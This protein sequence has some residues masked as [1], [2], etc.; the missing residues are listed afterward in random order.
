M[1]AD[2]WVIRKYAA[3]H[4]II[5]KLM[6]K[7]FLSVHGACGSLAAFFRKRQVPAEVADFIVGVRRAASRKLGVES[8]VVFRRF[9]AVI[10]FELIPIGRRALELRSDRIDATDAD[11]TSSCTGPTGR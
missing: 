11:R 1:P 3:L 2:F 9:D 10:A 5:S 6:D 4:R 7:C 8:R